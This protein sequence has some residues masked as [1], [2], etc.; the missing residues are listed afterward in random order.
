MNTNNISPNGRMPYTYRCI[1]KTSDGKIVSD[2]KPARILSLQ[3]GGWDDEIRI[4]LKTV[5]ISS[6]PPPEY[7]ALS[8]VW[9]IETDTAT[10]RIDGNHLF[11]VT[12]GLYTALRHLRRTDVTRIFWIDAICINQQDLVERGRQVAQMGDIYRTAT[13]VV[14]W[15]GLE[16]EH[17]K[18]ALDHIKR[19]CQFFNVDWTT[20]ALIPKPWIGPDDF[21]KT[22]TPFHFRQ[23]GQDVGRALAD[24]FFR[25]WFERVWIR[26]EI[27]LAKQ[28][29]AIMQCGRD[30]ILWSIF[31]DY[32]FF[33]SDKEC[34]Y[35][36]DD[37][38]RNQEVAVRVKQILELGTQ[39]RSDFLYV[40]QGARWAKCKDPR[41][42]IYGAL[43]IYDPG[44]AAGFVIKPDYTLSAAE[45]Y[46]NMALLYLKH[47][48]LRI[49]SY[50]GGERL[51]TSVDVSLPSWV[52]DWTVQDGHGIIISQPWVCASGRTNAYARL[53]GQTTLRI[54]GVIVSRIAEFGPEPD[55]RVSF[56]GGA[57]VSPRNLFKMAYQ[58]F[59][60][61]EKT[62]KGYESRDL[63]VEAYC[64][65]LLLGLFKD[66]FLSLPSMGILYFS[67]AIEILRDMFEKRGI[68]PDET[69]SELKQRFFRHIS[70]VLGK[71]A[72][73]E[74]GRIGLVPKTAIVGDS[75]CVFPG[76]PGVMVLRSTT[77]VDRSFSDHCDTYRVVGDA[78]FDDYMMGEAL[79]GELPEGC[80]ARFAHW[81]GDTHVEL[82]FSVGT[83]SNPTRND[84]RLGLDHDEALSPE[85]IRERRKEIT[86]QV[87]R[88]RGILLKQLDLI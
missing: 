74:A 33:V 8:Y 60:L 28:D 68:L 47:H 53:V 56:P 43:S 30:E 9:G 4:A 54:E 70:L 25:P 27:A 67:E 41:D 77:D 21:W 49:F 80:K 58:M 3:P 32:L 2:R 62:L 14:V 81:P 48:S 86:P 1:Y 72:I 51:K 46:K 55:L 50:T 52:P 29:K 20:N 88:D 42:R 12:S 15:L 7:E 75:L 22:T 35:S 16:G 5:D 45:V 83:K 10:V 59:P 85:Q 38:L 31:K 40:M 73:T 79:L 87:L 69:L 11:K 44:M 66:L 82:A 78:Y 61:C 24:L 23:D 19:M 76:C 17:S 57:D 64:K 71:V 18:L 36:E 39:T 26:Q 84:P 6:N 65:T 34:Y 37:I 13:R 63:L